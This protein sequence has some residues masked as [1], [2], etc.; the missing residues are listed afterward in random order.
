MIT[1]PIHLSHSFF[2]EVIDDSSVV[3]DGTMG[4]GN[5]TAFL[6]SLAKKVYAFDVQEEALVKTQER[7]QELGLTNA[8]LIL[9]GH[10]NLDNYIEEP[11]RAAIFNLGYLPSAEKSLITKPETTLMAL[12]KTLEVLEV[13]GR[14]AVMVYYGHQGGQEEK[15]ALLHFVSQ[16]DQRL[17][18]AMLYQP[19]NQIN[20]PPFLIMLEK[21]EPID[22]GLFLG[23]GRKE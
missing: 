22:K 23:K 6:A 9:D 15:E 2:K 4:K 13:G 16:L 17:V 11:I 21:L 14:I 10:E 8:D 20:R 1:R 7:L 19:L 3:L 5:D 18:T 12:S